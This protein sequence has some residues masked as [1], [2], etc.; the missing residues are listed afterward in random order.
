MLVTAEFLKLEEAYNSIWNFIFKQNFLDVINNCTLNL[1]SVCQRIITD[2]SQKFQ[3]EDLFQIK[4]R[5]DKFVGN[6]FKTKV[7]NLL[8]D[9]EIFKCTECQRVI[10]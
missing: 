4:D 3:L 10:T 6:I 2:V 9:V 5:P 8:H 1:S 7:E